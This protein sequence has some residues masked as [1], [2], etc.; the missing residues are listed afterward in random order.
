MIKK[1]N[2][3][4]N[5]IYHIGSDLSG[6]YTIQRN[7][8]KYLTKYDE[9]H[10]DPSTI[11]TVIVDNDLD[12]TVK[13][14]N[15]RYDVIMYILELIKEGYR[16]FLTGEKKLHVQSIEVAD[17]LS[18]LEMLIAYVE[19]LPN[20]KFG[21]YTRI[22]YKGK[23]LVTTPEINHLLSVLKNFRENYVYIY[24]EFSD[25][26]PSADVGIEHEMDIIKKMFNNKELNELRKKEENI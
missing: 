23:T 4:N 10:P 17:D 15:K 26:L 9:L 18:N 12:E 1:L 20:N 22:I 7:M 14:F 8:Q 24:K 25:D 2:E 3:T 5:Y 6:A 21:V 11:Y 16:G 19:S 13:S